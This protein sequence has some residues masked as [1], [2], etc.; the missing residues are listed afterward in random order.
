MVD[1][2]VQN[3]QL[4]AS[5]IG[6]LYSLMLTD[7]AAKVLPYTLKKRPDLILLDVMMP[8]MSGFDVCRQLKEHPETRD[9]PVIFLTAMTGE[10]DI[11]DAYEVGGVDYITKPFRT[12]E[13]LAR[14]AAHLTIKKQHDSIAALNT[15][16][17]EVN[18]QKDKLLGV[19]AHDMRGSIGSIGNVMDV[20]IPEVESMSPAEIR[21]YLLMIKN[22]SE[23]LYAMFDEL[24]MWAKS[25]F[26]DISCDLS[27]VELNEVISEAVAQVSTQAAN[28]QIEINVSI[29]RNVPLYVDY[30]MLLTI[31][32]NLLTNAVKFSHPGNSIEV[33]TEASS[34]WAEIAVADHGVGM[35]SDVAKHLFD[36]GRSMTTTGTKGEKGTGLG[37]D[38]CSDFVKK[39]GGILT[40]ESEEGKGS[41]FKFTMP[42]WTKSAVE[43]EG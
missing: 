37:L 33:K 43:A 8:E 34:G 31:L 24:L 21:D 12:K 25:K 23:R 28:K 29:E 10:D 9:I 5:I 19:I 36:T 14:I 26:Q 16:L 41:T 1:D 42:M 38:L 35:P 22:S 27:V 4:V 39:H 11:A 18:K 2:Q 3:L 7:S 15:E 17:M 40:V 13:L 32:R 30:V 6:P 20:L